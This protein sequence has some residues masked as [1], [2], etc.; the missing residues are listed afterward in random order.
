MDSI[1]QQQQED[2]HE[3]LHGTV[4]ADKIRELAE[5]AKTCFFCTNPTG[6]ESI[7]TRPMTVQKLDDEGNL[8]FLSANDSHTDRDISVDPSVKLY[9]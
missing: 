1:N 9:F 3:D 7:G 8:W 5:D 2:N 6:G 4:A